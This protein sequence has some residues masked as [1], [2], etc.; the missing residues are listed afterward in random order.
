MRVSPQIRESLRR[1]REQKRAYFSLVILSILFVCTLPAE[2]LCNSKPL[3]IRCREKFYFPVLFRYTEADFGGDRQIEPDYRSPR[4]LALIGHAAAP[5]PANGPAQTSGRNTSPSSPRPETI[6]ADFDPEPDDTVTPDNASTIAILNDFD[7]EPD[8]M[9][10]PGNITPPAAPIHEEP[11]TCW[12]L[13]PPVPYDYAYI[14][15]TSTSGRD[16]LASPW[17]QELPQ[18]GQQL[19]S[20]WQEQ[21]YLGTDDRGRDVL[22]RLIYGF[23]VSMLFGLLLACSGTLVGAALGAVQG[24][25]GGWTDLLGQRVTEIWGSLPQLYLL[26]ILSS[27]VARNIFVL[28]V[29]L[30]L[31]SWMGMAAYMRAE[32]LRGRNLDYVRAAKALGMNDRAVMFRHILPN[33]L[34]P[35]ITFFPFAVTGGILALVSLDFLGLG[36]PSPFPSLGELL[37]QG[38]A[39]LHATWII[40]PTFAVLSGTIMLLTFIGDGL[41][42]AF[43]PRRSARARKA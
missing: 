24:Y 43:D 26:M 4:F 41:R 39:N 6:L 2:L 34:T 21:H 17:G 9:P 12:V 18:S 8:D 36:V 38:Q 20:S 25:F 31:T 42:N 7:P 28:F 11:K 33:S 40:L 37:A 35:V 15:T 30:N 10:L 23:R 3:V 16:A 5:A 1:F 29:I 27:L 19:Q 14:S 32:F 22:A 13:W